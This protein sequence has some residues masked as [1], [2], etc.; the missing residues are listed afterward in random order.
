MA[1]RNTEEMLRKQKE[2][3]QKKM[4]FV[5]LPLFLGLVVWQGPKMYKAFLGPKPEATPPPAA[6][7]PA[8]AD[9]AAGTAATSGTGA[10]TTPEAP[11]A[12]LVDTDVPPE[13]GADRLVSLGR[14]ASRDPFGEPGGGG[15]GADEQTAPEATASSAVI[16][17]NGTPET[18]G[19]DGEFPAGDPTFRLVSLTAEAAVIGLVSGAFEGGQG[20]VELAVGEQ[21]EIVAEPDGTRY[22]IELVSVA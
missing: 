21:V 6:T 4:L 18:V 19:L 14:F 16:E 17:V 12:G 1:R 3:K 9:P 13:A 22:T 7:T 8:P 5:L 2:A 10:A 20:T 11:A 15:S